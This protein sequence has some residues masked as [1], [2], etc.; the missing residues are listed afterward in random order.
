M[1]TL[2]P[3]YSPLALSRL[4]CPRCR[5]AGALTSRTGPRLCPC[6]LRR[7]QNAKKG[8]SIWESLWLDSRRFPNHF[9]PHPVPGSNWLVD[10]KTLIPPRPTPKVS[11][12]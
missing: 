6:T 12:E 8:L 4:K 2:P 5:G 11:A 3:R 9:P 7:L 10:P 1:T